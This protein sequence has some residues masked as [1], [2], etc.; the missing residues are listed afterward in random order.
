MSTAKTKVITLDQETNVSPKIESEVKQAPTTLI[1]PLKKKGEL[2]P[3]QKITLSILVG[4][5]LLGA[6]AV[7][8]YFYIFTKP[9]S[10]SEIITI[11][12]D[13]L[14]QDLQIINWSDK[15]KFITTALTTPDL[16]RTEQSPLNG[17]LFTKTEI[18][19]LE[20]NRP[21][22][23]MINNHYHARPQSALN[24]A[25]IVYESLAE[26]GITRYM[27]IFW[28]QGTSKVGPVRSAR[29]YF[30]EWLSPYDPLY[31]H[32]GC[33]SS[34]DPRTN[35]CGNIYSY[36]IKDLRTH[37]YWRVTD[38]VAPHN[39][40]N[41][42]VTAWDYA[43]KNGW[44]G[45]PEIDTLQFKRDAE[46][47]ARGSRT[48]VKVRFRQDLPNNGLYDSEWSY[49]VKSNS[50]LH[51]IGGQADLDLETGKQVSAKVVVIQEVIMQSSGDAYGRIIIT[52]IGEGKAVVLQD[53]K[54]TIGKWKKTSRTERERYYDSTGKELLLNR[55][56]LWIT[57]VPK[58]QGKFDIIE[59]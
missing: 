3:W 42:T 30:L 13:Y 15:V 10:P 45:F 25:D 19:K 2:K 5:I 50:Y 41:S 23:I 57:A 44:G 8:M 29:Q 11:N 53:G 54:V 27:G 12:R 22:A 48:K 43:S 35:A 55:G 32:D 16:P 28:S 24:S 6:L 34:S 1:E 37:G 7:S 47:N 17:L 38:R 33:A 18:E 14:E 9:I 46:P 21:I 26:S 20:K 4:T 40:Y 59:Q 56:R 51:K 52:T 49:D 39:E 36:G 31:I 58:D